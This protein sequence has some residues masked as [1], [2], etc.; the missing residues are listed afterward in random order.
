MGLIKF[1]TT[2]ALQKFLL[3]LCCVVLAVSFL[4]T[5]PLEL[6]VQGVEAKVTIGFDKNDAKYP[7]VQTQIVSLK[8]VR[9][10]LEP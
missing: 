7:L 3:C 6:A 1:T 4:S 10:M 8:G 2:G 9:Q 5:Q